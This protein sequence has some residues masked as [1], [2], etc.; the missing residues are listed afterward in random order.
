[1]HKSKHRRI[2]KNV[3]NSKFHEIFL[4]EKLIYFSI[5][6]NTVF[7]GHSPWLIKLIL[8]LLRGPSLAK[9]P[10]SSKVESA[11]IGIPSALALPYGS[12]DRS[13]FSPMA[14]IPEFNNSEHKRRRLN[15]GYYLTV[16]H[17]LELDYLHNRHFHQSDLDG[18]YLTVCHPP[19]RNGHWIWFI[20]LR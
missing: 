19:H 15:H 3:W 14:S 12:P 5:S 9:F 4:I 16:C 10:T 2:Q 7:V 6:S 8:V 13:E 11:I 1:M 18:H 17:G 20:R